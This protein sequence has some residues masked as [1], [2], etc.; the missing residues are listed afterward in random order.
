MNS[1]LHFAIPCRKKVNEREG[2]TLLW[3][4]CS[5]KQNLAV[6]LEGKRLNRMHRSRPLGE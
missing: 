4:L 3:P 5:G 2:G 6:G 1:L